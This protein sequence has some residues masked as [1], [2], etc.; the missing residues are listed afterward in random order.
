MTGTNGTNL[1]FA[2]RKVPQSSTSFAPFELLY[3]HEVRGPASRD[4][5]G[6]PAKR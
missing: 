5:G 6:A 2:Y 1:L 3:G 4:M